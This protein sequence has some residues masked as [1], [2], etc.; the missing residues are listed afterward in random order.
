M[1]L[2]PVRPASAPLAVAKRLDM[3][4]GEYIGMMIRKTKEKL[5]ALQNLALVLVGFSFFLSGVALHKVVNPLWIQVPSQ[6]A[7]QFM[8]CLVW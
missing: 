3:I 5:K 2:L 7:Y 4:I 6:E 1:A 8:T